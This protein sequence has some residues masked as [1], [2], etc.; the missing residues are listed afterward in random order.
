[1]ADV[2]DGR[3]GLLGWLRFGHVEAG[4]LKAVQKE[5]GAAGIDV[6]GGDALKDFTDGELDGAAVFRLGQVKGAATLLACDRVGNR[7]A[8]SVMVVAKVFVAE[9]WTGAAASVGEDVAAL[10]A[11]LGTGI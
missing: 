9:S 1:M 7:F 11:H 10:E 8:S 3:D 4:N 2:V 5:T 6:I